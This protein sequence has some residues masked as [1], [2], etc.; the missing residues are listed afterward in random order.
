MHHYLLNIIS[1]SA[2]KFDEQ[3]GASGGIFGL[4]GACMAD[5]WINRNVLFSDFVNKGRSKKHHIKVI[6]IL[7]F[8]I[9]INLV[10]RYRL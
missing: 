5:I 9:F 7:A 6:V 10:S 4:T 2:M 3:V 1:S 8:D